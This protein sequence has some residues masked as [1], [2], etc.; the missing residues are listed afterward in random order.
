MLVN[1][2][3]NDLQSA[4]YVREPPI[5]GSIKGDVLNWSFENFD[6]ADEMLK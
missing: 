1:M 4:L 5:Y 2:F 6:A 3:T